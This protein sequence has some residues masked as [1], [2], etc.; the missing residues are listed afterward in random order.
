QTS[1]TEAGA[2]S[3]FTPFIGDMPIAHDS[4]RGSDLTSAAITCVLVSAATPQGPTAA[5]TVN[6]S[7]GSLKVAGRLGTAPSRNLGPASRS[8]KRRTCSRRLFPQQIRIIR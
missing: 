7:T 3:F 2:L 5:L 4:H 6:P 8:N 1:R